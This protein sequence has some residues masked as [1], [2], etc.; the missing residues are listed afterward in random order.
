MRRFTF[1]L[2]AAAL[3]LSFAPARAADKVTLLL[4]WFQLA[5]HSPFYMAMQKGYFAEEDIEL[6]I[7]RGQGSG[8][9]AAKVDLGQADF[10][11][12]DIPTV[13]T[14]ISKGANLTIVGVVYDKAA[15]N[16]FFY[17]DSGIEEVADLAGKAIAV[18]AGDSHRFLWPALAK[19]HDVDPD[20]VELVNVKPEGKQ[21][22]VA[23]RRVDGA[24]DLYTSYPIWEKA[25][26]E[27]QVGNLLFADQGIALYGHGYI[28]NSDLVEENPEL[29]ERFLR[30]TYKGWRDTYAER[31]AAIDAMM[32]EVPGIDREAYLANLD[33]VLD[34]VITERSEADGLGWIQPEL[35][36][37]TIDITYSGGQM[38]KELKAE[39]VFTNE[40]NSKI[41]APTG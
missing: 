8:D 20:S 28:V 5:D 33:L 14:A 11:I 9:T 10:G 24:F 36:Q 7:I 6:E 21:G 12:S 15:N 25:L 17:K 34:L 4:N 40:F 2:G 16:L 37:E 18:P 32:A 39:D 38:E 30:A 23:A 22:I 1:A 13:L 29:I 3:A 31:E 35:M 19:L 27:G 41:E 26:G